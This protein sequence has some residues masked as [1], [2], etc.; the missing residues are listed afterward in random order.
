MD[1]AQAE[2]FDDILD[3]RHPHFWSSKLHFYIDDIPFYN[4]PYTFGYL[5]S[6]GIY[7]WAQSQKDFEASYISL[8]R[9]TANM[10]TEELAKKHL[11]VDLTEP[12]FWQAGADLIKQ[13]IDEFISLSDQ[14]V[15]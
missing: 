3:K 15:K 7:A 5:F 10:S 2:A 11:G 4:F 6:S 14:F 1:V 13:D 9:D 8:L 12:D